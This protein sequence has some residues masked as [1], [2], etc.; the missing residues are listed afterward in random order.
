MRCSASSSPAPAWSIGVL[1]PSGELS[2]LGRVR[3]SIVQ[4]RSLTLEPGWCLTESAS[5]TAA[6]GCGASVGGQILNGP[7]WLDKTTPRVRRAIFDANEGPDFKIFA[8]WTQ[9][10]AGLHMQ[11]LRV[12]TSCN[13]AHADFCFTSLRILSWIER[14]TVAAGE[15]LPSGLQITGLIWP[16]QTE[17]TM[18]RCFIY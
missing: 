17:S 1:F 3:N 6:R 2:M 5:P 9:S 7:I 14:E 16:H 12:S 13:A 18:N 10:T 15:T 4:I 11:M 8:L